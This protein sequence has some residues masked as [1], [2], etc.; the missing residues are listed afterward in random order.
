MQPN[1]QKIY[2][3]ILDKKFPLLKGKFCDILNKEQ[4]T[5]MDVVFLNDQIFGNSNNEE[6]GSYNQKLRSYDEQTIL[7]ILEFQK[8]K[9]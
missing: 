9:K 3:D 6:Y 5:V 7:Y 1:Y 8:K 2:Q 4:F